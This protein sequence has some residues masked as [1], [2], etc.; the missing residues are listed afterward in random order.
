[1][2]IGDHS[3]VSILFVP[4]RLIRQLLLIFLCPLKLFI[5]LSYMPA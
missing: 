3:K 2:T 4:Q 5:G 1:M